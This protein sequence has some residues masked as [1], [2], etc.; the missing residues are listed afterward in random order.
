[1]QSI[2]AKYEKSH[3]SV[4]RVYI[5]RRVRISKEFF[6]DTSHF[7][8]K[9]CEKYPEFSPRKLTN[10]K[11]PSDT[12]PVFLIPT[13][14]WGMAWVLNGVCIRVSS[15]K[16][17]VKIIDKDMVYPLLIFISSCINL[18]MFVWI[19]KRKYDENLIINVHE[20]QVNKKSFLFMYSRFL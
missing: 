15:K 20:R 12:Y 8:L 9:C 10:I 5:C 13:A 1:M 16:Y 4:A 14:R 17:C 6:N 18:K 11:K 3:R 19:T 7:T 2:F